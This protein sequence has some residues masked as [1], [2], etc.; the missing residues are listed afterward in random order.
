MSF[1]WEH[2]RKW[3]I[4]GQVTT[5]DDD[6]KKLLH[7]WE[8][9]LTHSYDQSREKKDRERSIKEEKKNLPK[10]TSIMGTKLLSI[11][12]SFSTV[13]PDFNILILYVLLNYVHLIK[14]FAYRKLKKKKLF[15]VKH[16]F[17]L[18]MPRF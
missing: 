12:E 8:I 16:F 10:E 13:A 18:S 6:K 3:A 4:K 11:N 7:I 15:S 14:H 17:T 5:N 1:E 9:Y 2:E